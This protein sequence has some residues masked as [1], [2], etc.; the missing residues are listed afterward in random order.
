MH[1]LRRIFG[2]DVRFVSVLTGAGSLQLAADDPLAD[3]D[4]IYNTGPDLARD[5]PGRWRRHVDHHIR[6]EPALR[7][8]RSPG[9]TP[10]R[11]TRPDRRRPGRHRRGLGIGAIVPG[12]NGTFTVT[13]VESTTRFQADVGVSGPAQRRWRLRHLAPSS[14]PRPSSASAT[15]FAR[16]GGYIGDQ[17]VGQWLHVPDRRRP[18][19]PGLQPGSGLAPAAAS[20]AG[21]TTGRGQPGHRVPT[22]RPTSGTCRPT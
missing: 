6:S 17:R 5:R 19:R 11:P 3:I 8:P 16:G 7:Q 4:V 9:S 18:R 15:F 22:R 1:S 21:R 12:Y 14:T 13:A 20:P 10:P 2:E